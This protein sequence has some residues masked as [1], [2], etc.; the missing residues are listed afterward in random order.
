[1]PICRHWFD[2]KHCAETM[3]VTPVRPV[4]LTL[5]CDPPVGCRTLHEL[6]ENE[7]KLCQNIWCGLIVYDRKLMIWNQ[8]IKSTRACSSDKITKR[9]NQR[10]WPCCDFSYIYLYN[11][12]KLVHIYASCTAINWMKST[13]RS[14]C[15]GESPISDLQGNMA[16]PH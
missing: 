16:S 6:V 12:Q 2:W 10:Q 1:M 15:R 9:L 7:T 14:A 8:S 13:E 11:H 4:F 3:N 5:T